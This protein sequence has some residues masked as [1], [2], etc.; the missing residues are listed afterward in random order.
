MAKIKRK[1]NFGSNNTHASSIPSTTVNNI[2]PK[3]EPDVIVFND[4]YLNNASK[5]GSNIIEW[6]SFM[7][8][9][10]FLCENIFF[11]KVEFHFNF[12]FL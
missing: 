12:N 5:S 9:S 2:T 7:V 11:F 3:K 6:K 10:P 8:L 1:K 4:S